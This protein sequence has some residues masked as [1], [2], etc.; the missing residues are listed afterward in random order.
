MPFI[1]SIVLLAFIVA[2]VGGGG[3]VLARRV[4]MLLE[5]SAASFSPTVLS[6]TIVP[7]LAPTVPSLLQRH[8]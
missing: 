8:H 2:A 4:Q 7:S 3:L 1:V 6:L 5:I